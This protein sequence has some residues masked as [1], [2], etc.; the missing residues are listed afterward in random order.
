MVIYTCP[1]CGYTNQIKTHMKKHFLRKYLCKSVHKDVDLLYCFKVVLGENPPNYEK[2]TPIDSQKPIQ[3]TPIDSQMTLS[4]P[5][6]TPIDSQMTLSPPQVTPIDSY[7]YKCHKCEKTFSKNSNLHRHLKNCKEKAYT[8]E[9][10]VE[11]K[12]Q[13]A[14]DKDSVIHELKNQIEVLLTKAILL[15]TL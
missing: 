8:K 6:V 14:A 2:M 10:L 7:K 5:P 4:P 9:E 12:A 3:V 11:A 13:V 1:R 15:I